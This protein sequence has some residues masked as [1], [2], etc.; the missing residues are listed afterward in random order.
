M[1]T[2]LIKLFPINS[3]LIRLHKI[4]TQLREKSRSGILADMGLYLK[5]EN[6]QTELQRRIKAELRRKSETSKDFEVWTED[7]VEA[8]KAKVKSKKNHR[9]ESARH[10]GQA[11]LL[12]AIALI[13]VIGYMAVM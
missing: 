3:K 8:P 10:A 7:S 9:A 4:I 5:E 2:S 13:V 1:I 11:I 12:I 6:K